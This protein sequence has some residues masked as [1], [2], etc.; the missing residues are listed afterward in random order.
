MAVCRDREIDLRCEVMNVTP[1]W[2]RT[3]RQGGHRPL[4][5]SAP[6]MP[7]QPP[8]PFYEYCRTGDSRLERPVR[9]SRESCLIPAQAPPSINEFALF[10]TFLLLLIIY[11]VKLGANRLMRNKNALIAPKSCLN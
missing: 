7:A 11:L 6:A 3:A 1:P 5:S 10:S 8:F 4:R 2:S 9:N